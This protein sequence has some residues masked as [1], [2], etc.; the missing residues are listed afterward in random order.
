VNGSKRAEELTR[1]VVTRDHKGTRIDVFLASTTNLSRRASRRILADGLVWMNGKPLRVQSRTVTSGDVIDVLLPAQ[2]LGLSPLPDI[3]APTILHEDRWLL[4]AAKPAGILSAAAENMQPGESAFDEQVLLA[5]AVETGK[6][7][8][9]RLFHRLDRVTSGAI[10]F[11]R[12]REA[13]PALTKAWGG[14]RVERVYI[15]VVEGVPEFRQIEIDRPISR[16]R[17]HQWRFITDAN[18]RESRTETGVIAR[19]DNDLAVVRCRLITGR[20]HQVRVHLASI[21][22]PVLGDR[23]YG[24]KRA[25]EVNRP[26]LHAAS[27]S[28]PHPRTGDR[29]RV[30]CPEPDD[31]AAFLPNDQLTDGVGTPDRRIL[32]Q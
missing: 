28:L 6:R 19:L 26:L 30:V 17:L 10:L 2:D 23:L 8:F 5:K 21:G 27:L 29:L 1:C 7:P 25:D 20:T 3:V 22:H 31:I 4:V 11:A 24:S 32:R 16:D 14:G 12:H 15:A 9:L 18:G 13:L